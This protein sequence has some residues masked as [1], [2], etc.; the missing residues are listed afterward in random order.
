MARDVANARRFS[1]TTNAVVVGISTYGDS[2]LPDL[3]ACSQ[4]AKSVAEAFVS[5]RGCGIPKDQ[6]RLLV[7]AEATRAEIL[8]ALSNAASKAMEDEILIFYFAGH[9]V[10]SDDGFVLRTG[11]SDPDL[12]KGVSQNDLV[13]ALSSATA[14][15]ILVILDSCGGAKI[16]ENASPYF[17]ALIGKDFRLLISAS[18][19]GQS[20]WELEGK[21]SLLTTRLLRVLDG[22][23]Q[24]GQ[25]G[26]IYFRDLF[27][28]L[29]AGVVEDAARELG[30]G[31]AQTPIFAGSHADDPLLFLNRDITLAEVR[32]RV[33]RITPELHRRRV[34]VAMAVVVAT[35]LATLAGYWAFLDSHQY[36]ELRRDNI[37][38][39]LQLHLL[40]NRDSYSSLRR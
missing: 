1:E 40:P 19:A 2:D 37:A 4:E 33:R 14:R 35:V 31:D 39:V 16:A 3:P 32:V 7:D 10:D 38:L 34:R 27:D 5:L 8:A 30:S 12:Q 22:S 13:A 9:G 6:V 17:H 15:G 24:L 29:Y 28:Y 36:F 25:P 11:A 18:R 26:A 23:E 20:S 21:G